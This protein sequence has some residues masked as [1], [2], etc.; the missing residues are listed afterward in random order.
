VLLAPAASTRAQTPPPAKPVTAYGWPVRPFNKP[1]PVR[2]NF[3]DPRTVFVDPFL[4]G[5]IDGPGSFSFHNGVDIS[6]PG[7]TPVYAVRSGIAHII[8]GSM[9]VVSAA[10][11]SWKF[12]YDHLDPVVFET[13][14]VVARK[15]VLGTVQPSA[16]HVHLSELEGTNVVNPA[17]KGHLTPYIDHTKPTVAR[18]DVRSPTGESVGPIAICGHVSVVASVYDRPQLPIPGTFAGLPVAPAWVAW[19]VTKLDGRVVVPLTVRVDFRKLLPIV[20]DFWNVYARGT[21]QNAP[22]FGRQQF[23][24]MP[25]RF[26]YILD[27]SLDTRMLGNGVSVV[28]VIAKDIRG[29]AAALTQRVSVLNTTTPAGCPATAVPPKH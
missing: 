28:T 26:L 7:G 1:H 4:G 11:D 19:K 10:D 6:A 29:N 21:Y 25:G 27:P 9:V 2:A 17:Q 3:G 8:S 15:T 16:G 13:Q 5:G 24:G 23:G 20:S 18:I 22:R 12:Q 14:A